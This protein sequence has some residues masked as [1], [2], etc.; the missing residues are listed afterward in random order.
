[1]ERD[2]FPVVSPAPVVR[3]DPAIDLVRFTCL[4]LVVAAHCMMVSPA[5]LKGGTVTTDNVLMDQGWFTPVAWGLMIVPL[6]FVLGGVTGLESW[7]R[8]RARGG[9][10]FAFAQLRLLRLV[11]PAMALLAVMWGGL[12]LALLLGVHPQV[13]QL[14]AAG[15]AMPLWFLAAY[16]AAQLSVPLMARLHEHAPLLTFAALVAAIITIDS[17]RGALPVL[18]FTNLIFVW[19]AVQQLGFFMADGFFERRSRTW[20]VGA[21]VSSN[22]VLG[23]V[24]GVAVYPG[25]MVVNINPPNLCLLLLGIS[26]AATLQLLHG[27]ITWLAGVGWVQKII[28]VAGRRSMTVYLWHLPLLVGMS[29]LLLLTDVPKPLAGTAEWWWARIPVF[30]AVVAL[31]VPVVWLFGRLENRPTAASHARGPS[32]TEVVTAAVVVL[33]PVADAA[34]NGLTLALLGGGAACFALSVLLLGRVPTPVLP[35][36]FAVKFPAQRS[37]HGPTLP[38]PGFSAN[39][40]P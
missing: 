35:P 22:L 36:A 30:F 28:A 4:L 27:G 17:L 5:L 1:M 21:I 10:G 8:L 12:W 7:R 38:E 13:I 9:T 11:R 39:L 40:E 18:A 23:L 33:I 3:R 15:A 19:C 24:T 6:F 31:L 34:F 29:G 25:N 16:L 20:L 26:Q 2:A 14:M 37:S 32:R